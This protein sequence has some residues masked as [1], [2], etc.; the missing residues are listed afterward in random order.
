EEIKEQE[1]VK[2]KLHILHVPQNCKLSFTENEEEKLLDCYDYRG[3]QK[4]LRKSG[5]NGSGIYLVSYPL[6][7]RSAVQASKETG[8]E[9]QDL[10]SIPPHLL[11]L[12]VEE[13]LL[14]ANGSSTFREILLWARLKVPIAAEYIGFFG[15]ISEAIAEGRD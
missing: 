7:L 8:L 11:E 12:W 14:G 4:L 10:S 2:T 6:P 15:I 3:A 13:F 5:I 9:I 1:K